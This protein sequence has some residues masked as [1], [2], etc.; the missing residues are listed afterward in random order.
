MST[1]IQRR[2]LLLGSAAALGAGAFSNLIQAPAARAALPSKII[3]KDQISVSAELRKA[4]L[5]SPRRPEADKKR[6]ADR[7]PAETMAFYG[8]KP[9]MKVSELMASRGYFTAVL[10]ETVGDKGVVYGQNNKWLRERFKDTQRPLADLVDKAGYKNV[11]EQNTELEDLQLPAG[12]LDAIFMVMFYHDMYWLG[13]NRDAVNK[14]VMAALKPGGIYGII[15]HHA[16]PG[17]GISDVNKNHRIERFAVVEDIE[18]SGFQL[19]EETDLLEN[20]KDPLNINVFQQE[21]RGHTHQFVLKFKK[22]A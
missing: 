8:I 4:I 17:M 11:V 5:E 7:K 16:A 12:Q 10:A 9:G 15:D 1:M 13:S 22:P 20:T 6:D 14:S 18:K 2:G 19:V 3:Y 21:L